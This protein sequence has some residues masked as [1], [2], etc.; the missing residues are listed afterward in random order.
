MRKI[1]SLVFGDALSNRILEEDFSYHQ[2][3]LGKRKNTPKKKK[4]QEKR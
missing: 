3:T 2:G 4:R 1:K